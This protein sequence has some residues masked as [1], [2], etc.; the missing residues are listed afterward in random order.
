M[1]AIDQWQNHIKSYQDLVYGQ[2]YRFNS[3]KN[4]KNQSIPFKILRASGLSDG[5][6]LKFDT[7]SNSSDSS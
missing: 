7:D 4:M 6:W 2:C 3:G 5:F 1:N